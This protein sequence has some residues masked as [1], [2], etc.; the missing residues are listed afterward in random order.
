LERIPG[1]STGAAWKACSA[2]W[3][4]AEA[5]GFHGRLAIDGIDNDHEKLIWSYGR[6]FPLLSLHLRAWPIRIETSGDAKNAV[7]C[8][9]AGSIDPRKVSIALR[10]KSGR[11]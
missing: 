8:W 7:A 3:G 4:T 5:G 6:I 10:V 1:H 2:A 9:K 11:W